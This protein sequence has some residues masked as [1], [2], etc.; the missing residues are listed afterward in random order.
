MESAMDIRPH[1]CS[2][3]EVSLI[4]A[5]KCSLDLG[6]RCELATLR[7]SQTFQDGGKMCR[8]D[9]FGLAL[10]TCQRHD[11]QYAARR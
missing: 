10:V 1:Y 8:I 4:E 7:L 6:I 5:T 2:Q 3:I 9:C 11:Q